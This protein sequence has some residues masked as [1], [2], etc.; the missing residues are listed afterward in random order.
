[1]PFFAYKARNARGELVSGIL[2]SP[3][4]GAVADQLFNTGVTPVEISPTNKTTA[5]DGEV[6]LA[7]GAKQRFPSARVLARQGYRARGRDKNGF[8]ER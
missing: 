6:E 7:E 4:S 1:M 5:G 8:A 3:D 2:E